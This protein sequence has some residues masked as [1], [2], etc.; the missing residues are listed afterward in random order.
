ME[1]I[2]E[3]LQ[4]QVKEKGVVDMIMEMKVEMEDADIINKYDGDWERIGR[5][6]LTEDFIERHI[7]KIEWREVSMA[8]KLSIE[9]CEKYYE[10]INWHTMSYNWNRIT[11]DFVWR[12]RNELDMTSVIICGN[13][14]RDFCLKISNMVNW[15]DVSRKFWGVHNTF[16]LHLFSDLLDWT[17]VF[18]NNTD[19]DSDFYRLYSNRANWYIVMGAI[20]ARHSYELNGTDSEYESE[21]EDESESEDYSE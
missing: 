13:I 5:Y 20:N 19:L 8:S 4:D 21:D 1:N 10:K 17:Q 11:E 7:E 14:G 2:K 3:Y 9:F 16:V 6:G 15:D 12:F 18:I